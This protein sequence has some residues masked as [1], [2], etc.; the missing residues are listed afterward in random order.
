MFCP[1]CGNEI[2]DSAKFCPLCGAQFGEAQAQ[3]AAEP[4]AQPMSQPAYAQPQPAPSYEQPQSFPQYAAP[5]A[6]A[7]A[8]NKPDVAG[9]LKN[10]FVIIGAAAAVVIVLLIVLFSV[11]GGSSSVGGGK[12]IDKTHSVFTTDDGIVVFYGSKKLDTIDSDGCRD[13]GRS[14]DESTMYIYTYDNELYYISGEKVDKIDEYDNISDFRISTDGSTLVYSY[15]DDGVTMVDMYRNGK[16]SPE[17][18]EAEDGNLNMTLSPNGDTLLYSISEDGDTVLYAYTGSKSEKIKKNY[19]PVAVSNGGKTAYIKDTEKGGLYYIKNLK[20]DTKEKVDG[21]YS[22]YKETTSDGSA[23]MYTDN[24]GATMVYQPSF[25]KPVKVSKSNISLV[26]PENTVRKL[27]SFDKFI[28]KNGD[29]IMIY[30]RKGDGYEDDKIVSDCSSYKISADGSTIVYTKKGKL[31]KISA[32]AGAKAKEIAD[33]L[34]YDIFYASSDLSKIY[35]PNED[36]ELCCNNP[37][38]VVLD[39]DDWD[40]INSVVITTSGVLVMVNSDDELVYSDGGAVKKISD[41]GEVDGF[42]DYFGNLVFVRAD[43][44][45]WISEDGKSFKSTGVEFG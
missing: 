26:F 9:L 45:L 30:E 31:S 42:S 29:N 34:E 3:P 37:E 35:F 4:A 12:A 11:F 23:I 43:D 6:E 15:Y 44:E 18:V 2:P 33:D 22:S 40:D 10:K 5:V 1:T 21:D 41:P 39:E 36:G 16:L 7:P 19:M 38:K 24:S 13:S 14:A 17:I 27:D 25:K 20:E 28:A 32:K 8:A